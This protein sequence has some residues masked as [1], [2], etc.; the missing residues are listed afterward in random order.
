MAINDPFMPTDLMCYLLK[1]DS[2]HGRFPGTV[3]QVSG[4]LKVNGEFVPVFHEPI[5]ARISWGATGADYISESQG[6]F[7]KKKKAEQHL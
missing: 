1:Y 3:E 2:V 6:I 4:G 5:P 7:L